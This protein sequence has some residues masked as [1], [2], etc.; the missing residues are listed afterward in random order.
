VDSHLVLS[1]ELVVIV[2]QAMRYNPLL[3][4]SSPTFP[5]LYALPPASSSSLVSASLALPSTFL[6]CLAERDLHCSMSAKHCL[7]DRIYQKMSPSMEHLGAEDLGSK[8]VVNA[9]REIFLLA[10]V[11]LQLGFKVRLRKLLVHLVKLEASMAFRVTG[12]D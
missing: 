4:T 7:A 8:S 1:S 10:W 5:S 6:P 11:A 12:R 9:V 3:H 2:W